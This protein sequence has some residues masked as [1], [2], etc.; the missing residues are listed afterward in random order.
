M[1]SNA[2][3]SFA[4]PDVCSYFVNSVATASQRPPNAYGPTTRVKRLS[5][6]TLRPC[7]RRH[8]YVCP[9]TRQTTAPRDD[10]TRFA[11]DGTWQR[12]TRAEAGAVGMAI[13]ASTA[14]ATP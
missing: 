4:T 5:S 10:A 9:P 14:S 1:R 3:T 11:A 12:S 7:E 13:T 2:S 8:A 6:R